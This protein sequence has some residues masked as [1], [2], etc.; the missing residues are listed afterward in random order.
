MML[1]HTTALQNIVNKKTPAVQRNFKKAMR[2]FIDYCLLHNLLKLD[3]LTGL[4][5]AKIR[6]KG[7]HTWTAEEIKQFQ[8][9]HANGSKARLAL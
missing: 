3:P 4:K 2:G 7:H 8:D 1:L 6:T 5:M 9:R